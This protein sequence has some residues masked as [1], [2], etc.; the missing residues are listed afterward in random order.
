[1]KN[2][3]L[4]STFCDYFSLTGG[5]MI[6]LFMHN[7]VI[8]RSIHFNGFPIQYLPDYCDCFYIVP[9][10]Q[11]W[12]Q[13]SP[14]CHLPGWLD[15]WMSGCRSVGAFHSPL[16]PCECDIIGSSVALETKA[17]WSV[18]YPRRESNFILLPY[19]LF[20]VFIYFY[21]AQ[22]LPAAFRILTFLP[23]LLIPLISEIIRA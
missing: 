18:M 21:Y 4:L 3:R 14:R 7:R 11:Q 17:P 19:Y 13:F 23:L 5:K 10:L 16:Q 22:G 2:V 15:G 9:Y 12:I 20:P 8:C 6:N 1:M